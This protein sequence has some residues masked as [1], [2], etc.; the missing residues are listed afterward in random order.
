MTRNM[1]EQLTKLRASTAQ[2][3]KGQCTFRPAVEALE[4]RVLPSAAPLLQ[5]SANGRYLVAAGT[6]QPFYL[7]GDSLW[8][9]FA[10]NITPT[11]AG[12]YLQQ[13]AS[14]GFNAIL[15]NAGDGLADNNGDLPFLK[16]INGNPATA[17]SVFN[18]ATPNPAYWS[19]IDHLINMASQNGI[20]VMLNVAETYGPNNGT[21]DTTFLAN[22]TT[23]NLTAFGQFLG[24]RYA[25]FNNIIWMFG[26]DYYETTT[27]DNA[28]AAMMQGIRQFDTKHL[29][30][31]EWE[32]SNFSPHYASF[33]ETALRQYLNLNGIY[34]YPTEEGPFRPD[35]LA[36]YNRSDFGPIFNIETDYENGF[37]NP[38]EANI[39]ESHYSFLVDGATG[40][41]YGNDS[42]W[43]F[44]SGWQ[45]QLTSEGSHEM[46]YYANLVN[47]LPWYSLLPDQSGSVFQGVGT[48][49]ST[50]YGSGD[51]SGAY[52]AD[53]TM[54]I[55][56]MP[57]TGGTG[58]Q[59]FTVHMSKFSGTVTAQ[60]FDPTNGTYATIGTF[61]N[62]GDQTFNSPTSNSAGQ[63]DFVL[64][65]KASPSTGQPPAIT[66]ANKTTFTAG[67]AGTFTVTDTGSPTPTLSE[68][69]TLPSGVSFNASTGVLSGTPAAGS[70]GTYN[71]VF[72][73]SNGVGS[74]ATQNF[75][76]TVNQAPA[77][78]SAGSTVFTV[79][80]AGTFTLTGTGFPAPSFSESG[81]LPSG[82]T[83][84]NGVLSGTPA[85]GTGGAYNLVFTASNGVGSNATQNFTLT[86]KQ[87]P[88]ITSASSA[89]FT[90]GSA[91]NFTVTDSGFP[92]PTLSESGTLPSGVTFN[93]STGV[94]SGT[95]AAGSNGTY[96]LVFT[97][98][99]GVGSNATQ[100]FAF[101]VNTATGF[102]AHINF[103][104][105]FQTGTTP[106]TPDTVAGYIN[107]IG[108]ALGS[109][110]GGLTFG[111]NVDNTANGRDR[112]ATN[113]PD[114]LHDSLIHMN[115][116]G[117]FTWSIAVP[118][119]TY[120]VHVITGDPSN[121]DVVSKLTVNGVLT[122]NG[123]NN[124]GSLWLEGTST[125]TVTNGLI[126][127]AEQAGAYDKIDAIDIVLQSASATAP[128]IS[129][130]PS[131]QTVNA[132]Q[133]VTFS[134][135][136]S[137]TAPLSYQWQKSGANI[138]GATSASY[139]ISAAQAS[140]AGNYSVV[141]SNSA[142]SV[143][144]STA[145]LTV[146]VAPSITSQPASVTITAGQPASFNVVATGTA[147]LSY[148]WQKLVSGNWTNV[149]TNS[150]TLAISA[151]ASTDAGSYHVTVSNVAGSATS[152]TAT[153]TVNTASSTVLAI[154]AGNSA[155]G[156]FV[157]DTDFSGGSVSGGTTATIDT[158]HLT[159]PP[160]QSVLQHGRYGNMTYTIPNLTPGAT[161]TVRLDFVEYYWSA[162]G[163][164]VFNVAIN[165]TQVLSNFD[166]FAAAG[167]KNIAIARTFTA[168]ADSTGKITITFTSIVDNAMINGIEILTGP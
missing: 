102:A 52:T 53:G 11:Q 90:T 92:A 86:V 18:V 50:S 60:W 101:T 40:D 57:S 49:T 103:T 26:D 105:N 73:A 97:A 78:T 48:P 77:I 71:L 160:P 7:L 88:A 32:N 114:E 41:M 95:P 44:A 118:N 117:T 144:S 108:K 51:Y 23:A 94:L 138:A 76:L 5:I 109:N 70:G 89:T 66:S 91:G 157:A 167:G 56:Y 129:T 87:A 47:S 111:W 131:S 3:G 69:G 61:A 39:R 110:G 151:A 64:I 63:N 149:G 4:T 121:T 25:S 72:T 128:S 145:T 113:S 43:P 163:Q 153:L 27:L 15:M 31:L 134:V 152:S 148:Q 140:D 68:S 67:S 104:G 28:M 162:A 74:N 21:R 17:T 132:G 146:N 12:Q 96:N 79:G 10:A 126:Q 106:T 143:T 123:S 38:T 156:S 150:A 30:T 9:G 136:T 20:E 93:A 125:I 112:Q 55:A 83:F 65:L 14:Q 59:S 168:T 80:S 81:A 36:Q 127:V 135:V 147:P 54:A 130:Q 141:V 133:G 119:G 2:Q 158:S 137:G 164:R 24:Q 154:A 98:S 75:T 46:T 58:S 161:Y 13:R 37:H 35:Y 8:G 142:G 45:T 107:D 159:N 116:N 34:R 100:N 16:D 62:T 120:S 115:L 139:T 1:F 166:I 84:S 155:V 33:D 6:N 22:N 122:V 82:V 99:N 124:A 19:Y 85:A 29:I 42:L 165:G